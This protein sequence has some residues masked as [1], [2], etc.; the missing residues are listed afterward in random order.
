[1]LVWII[2][3]VAAPIF[4]TPP[5]LMLC[6]SLY[7]LLLTTFYV[8][9]SAAVWNNADCL[10]LHRGPVDEEEQYQKSAVLHQWLF[11]GYELVDTILGLSK[12]GRVWL[13]GTRKKCEF[14]QPAVENLPHQTIKSITLLQKNKEDGNQ[15]NYETLWNELVTASQVNGEKKTVGVILKERNRN[16]GKGIL[17]PWEERLSKEQTAESIDLVDIGNGLGF[18]MCVKD[19]EE[20]E[21]MKKS[22]VLSN[23]VMKHGCVKRLEKIID[24]EETITHEDLANYIEGIVEG[25]LYVVYPL[26]T[27]LVV[28]TG[29]VFDSGSGCL[30]SLSYR[31]F[32]NQSASS[33]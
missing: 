15:A 29:C 8:L 32:E 11:R 14:V 2:V 6:F 16:T 3:A 12:D 9:S 23:K 22:S 19:E 17:G 1:M 13:C 4:C 5:P 26:P 7:F 27:P 10:L 24:S 25:K 30:F 21:V 33:N 18:A 31:P 20:L 28:V